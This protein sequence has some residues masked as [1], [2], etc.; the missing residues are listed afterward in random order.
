MN[1][2]QRVRAVRRSRLCWGYAVNVYFM[3]QLRAKCSKSS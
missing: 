2:A 1:A 3:E